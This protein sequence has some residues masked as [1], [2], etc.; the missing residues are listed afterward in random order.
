MQINFDVKETHIHVS[1]MP[2]SSLVLAEHITDWKHLAEKWA[3]HI[4][5]YFFD[6]LKFV[7]MSDDPRHIE[8]THYFHYF[9][10]PFA[11]N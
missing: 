9:L 3:P 7:R 4:I 5:N 11:N 6:D 2:I 1:I 10:Y 8:A